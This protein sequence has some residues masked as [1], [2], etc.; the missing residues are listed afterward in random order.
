MAQTREGGALH[1]ARTGVTA[2]N[3]Q[4]QALRRGFGE[5]VS[6]P[7]TSTTAV[8]VHTSLRP[9]DGWALVLTSSGSTITNPSS[10]AGVAL[11]DRARRLTSGKARCYPL[12]LDLFPLE[13]GFFRVVQRQVVI[14]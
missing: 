14:D 10:T 5:R 7:A 4:R 13:L 3:L 6:N 8:N 9:V 12:G 11:A 1:R 2:T